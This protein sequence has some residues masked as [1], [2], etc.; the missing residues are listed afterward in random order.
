M[1]KKLAVMAS[2]G[3][4]SALV[5]A[6]SPVAAAAAPATNN[7]A[8]VSVS[9]GEDINHN[10]SFS[11]AI[12]GNGRYV[13][14]ASEQPNLVPGGVADN[15][16][17]VFLRDLVTGTTTQVSH[18]QIGFLEGNITVSGDGRYV[19]Y[20]SADNPD[21]DNKLNLY[22]R[23]AGTTQ[24]ISQPR[25]AD[26]EAGVWFKS[27]ITS[28][29]RYV[30]YVRSTGLD[31]DHITRHLYRY[32][33]TT[34][35]TSLVITGDLGGATDLLTDGAIPSASST[36]R[37]IAYVKASL[38]RPDSTSFY[39]IFRIDTV[40]GVKQ[41]LAASGPAYSVYS[42]F[43]DPSI[44]N[45]GRYVVFTAP[46]RA[47]DPGA[48]TPAGVVYRY[49]ATTGALE[50]V[51]KNM[52]G[53]KPNGVSGTPQIS[54]DGRYVVYASNA[55][56]LVDGLPARS[57]TIFLYDT[58]GGTTQPIVRNLQGKF[59]PGVGAQSYLPYISRTGDTIA[60]TTEAQNLSAGVNTRIERV[61]AWQRP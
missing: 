42:A 8:L 54:G 13:A 40:T 1:L 43:S 17:Y 35:T 28:D 57:S 7:L 56:D 3:A 24:V 22:D 37:Y 50:L 5:L 53:E 41:V 34:K 47:G 60:F 15:G 2:C 6:G 61:Y 9:S 36:G 38:P 10:G 19:V 58:V 39:R 52:S 31:G 55:T 29:G 49:D 48:N 4:L 16:R 30:I 44:S 12:S 51:S 33:T 26:E 27:D 11:Q 20:S 18:G 46:P 21:A 14:F 59:P 23:V 32:D 45:D 25:A